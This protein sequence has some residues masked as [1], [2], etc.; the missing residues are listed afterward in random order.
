M[1]S[2]NKVILMG[3]LTR[4]PELRRTPTGSVV[5]DIRLAVS[6]TFR[7]KAGERVERTVF[8]DVSTWGQQAESCGRYLRKGMPVFID[9]RLQYDEWK[10]PQGESR[11]KIRVVASR[12][13]FMSPIVNGGTAAT[14]QQNRM[15]SDQI[16]P[17]PEVDNYQGHEP[18]MPDDMEDVPF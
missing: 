17:P 11:S 4:D 16:L 10:T 13:Q 6:E 9:G 3:N 5:C 18:M 2:F 15:S 14:T 8:I 7:D 1:P 12:V